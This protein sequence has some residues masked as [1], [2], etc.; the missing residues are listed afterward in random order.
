MEN[1]PELTTEKILPIVVIIFSLINIINHTDN[2]IS[3][4]VLLSLVGIAG[5][6]L[7][8]QRKPISTK[9][10]Y[11]WLI[12]QI[13]SIEPYFDLTQS[14]FKFN[15]SFGLGMENGNVS[16]NINILAIL[17][18]GFIKVLEAANL[19]GKKIT[20]KEFR[21]SELE[22]IFPI[23]GLITNRFS[24]EN[25][26]NW[27]LVKLDNSFTYDGQSVNQILIKRKDDKTIKL[28]EKNQISFLRVV[29]N[30]NDLI[31]TS[32]KSKFPFID[33]IICE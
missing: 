29:L 2:L 7:F 14:F 19:V 10:I 5:S 33:W 3:L 17:M 13:I 26:K 4:S 12:A 8:F 6:Y 23:E 28:K 1:K 24:L 31:T 16:L 30:E 21:D 25:E 22:N 11:I 32:D 20:I 27:L 9:L 18:L 15:F